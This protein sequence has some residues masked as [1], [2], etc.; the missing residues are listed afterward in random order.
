MFVDNGIKET[1][2]DNL[3]I[4]II[5][6]RIIEF[7][8]IE[9]WLYLLPFHSFVKT[10]PI[11][12]LHWFFFSMYITQSCLWWS[13]VSIAQCVVDST[14]RYIFRETLYAMLGNSNCSRGHCTNVRI[15]HYN[16]TKRKIFRSSLRVELPFASLN[17]LVSVF[18][19]LFLPLVYLLQFVNQC[20]YLSGSPP[21]PP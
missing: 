6:V 4:R 2:P 19:L 11:T 16:K 17:H 10:M 18:N 9:I 8:I 1:C 12:S 20:Q 5:E 14:Q 7:R 21:T 3:K 13:F 15:K